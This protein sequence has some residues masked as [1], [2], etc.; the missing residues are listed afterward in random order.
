MKRI[1]TAAVAVFTALS[2]STGV[3][4]AQGLGTGSSGSD[5]QIRKDLLKWQLEFPVS[6]SLLKQPTSSVSAAN[7]SS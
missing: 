2:L 3:A 7:K 5:S 1:S 6:T 4:P